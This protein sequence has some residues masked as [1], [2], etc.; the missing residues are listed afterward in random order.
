MKKAIAVL[1]VL[2]LIGGLFLTGCGKTQDA[3]KQQEEVPAEPG[4]EEAKEPLRVALVLSG[5]LGDRSFY[6]SSH[7]GF[8][9]AKRSWALKEASWNAKRSI[10]L[11][12]QLVQASEN[13]RGCR[14]GRL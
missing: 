4:E 1:L 11:Q 8:E 13:A 14:S 7:E 12:D 10:P 2:L 5:G 3:E 9:R 6:D